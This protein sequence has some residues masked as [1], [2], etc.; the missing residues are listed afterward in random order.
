MSSWACA[1]RASAARR[2]LFALSRRSD[3]RQAPRSSATGWQAG[4]RLPGCATVTE[5]VFKEATPI[6][7]WS[8]AASTW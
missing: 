6:G 2:L 4:R 1:D 8:R 7:P 5:S 3:G